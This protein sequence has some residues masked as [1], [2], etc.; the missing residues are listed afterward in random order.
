[1]VTFS[2]SV[3]ARDDA[4]L[5]ALL[6]RRPD[7]ASP[8]PST[9]LSLAARAMSRAS[10]HRAVVSLDVAHLEVLESVH[11]LEMIGDDATAE[12][13]IS[14]VLGTAPAAESAAG[15]VGADSSTRSTA[16]EKAEGA[17]AP[18]RSTGTSA[19]PDP[20]DAPGTPGTLDPGGTY[21]A[22][23]ARLLSVLSDL[24]E[25]ALLWRPTPTTY[26]AAPGVD[27]VQDT[28]PAGLGPSSAGSPAPSS[29]STSSSGN[30]TP[31]SARYL[32]PEA[33][34][35]TSASAAA[36]A[37]SP[38]GPAGHQTDWAAAVTPEM[39]AALEDAPAGARSIL[40]ALTW[41]PP[42]GRMPSTADGPTAAPTRWLLEQGFV[43]KADAHHVLLPREV[44]LA[45]RGG[46]THR[47]LSTPPPLP[48]PALDPATV[49]AESAR[50]AQEVVRLVTD[51]VAVW[52]E[53]PAATLR[54]GGLGVRDLRRL[55]LRLEV[56]ERTAAFVVELASMA[57]LVVDDGDD[58]ASFAPTLDADDWL[59]ED[60]PGRWATL[61]SAWHSSARTPWLVGSRD[62]RGTLRSAL[63]PELHR[64]WVPRLRGEVLGVLRAAPAASVPADEVT[65]VLRWRAPRAVPPHEA[66][67]ALLAEAALLGVTGAG[68]LSAA[69]E[70]LAGV[71]VLTVADDAARTALAGAMAAALPDAVDDL[72]LQGDLTGIVPGRPTPGLEALLA[73]SAAVE[74]RGS[75]ITVRFTPESVTRALD[76]GR[77]G[78]E[79]L[80]EL[81]SHSRSGLPQPLE[82]LVRD[83][84][85]RHGQLRLGAA[86]S[87]V[88][89]EDP[90]LL[91]GLVEDPRLRGLGLFR[92]APTVLAASAAPAQLLA[93]L[94]ERG[95]APAMEGPDGQ[96]VHADRRTPRVRLAGRRGRRRSPGVDGSTRGLAPER[97]DRLLALVAVLRRGEEQARATQAAG[98]AA[99]TDRPGAGGSAGTSASATRTAA[100]VSARRARGTSPSAASTRTTSTNPA[101]SP[102]SPGAGRSTGDQGGSAQG[103]PAAGPQLSEG[104]TEPVVA[105]ALLREA[106]ADGREVLVDIVGPSG[107]VTRRRLR[108]MR[109]DAGRLRAVD[110]ARE[111]EL[112]VAVHRIANVEP[113]LATP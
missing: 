77:T 34:G 46:R 89:V 64:A 113:I 23:V 82:Y 90:V 96:V 26:R 49:E 36:S 57:G 101:G 84:A 108:P 1:M 65:A 70:V 109:L 88:R 14:A 59:A 110:V 104:T 4:R 51:L 16:P 12:R 42:V 106:A 58:P 50:A 83:A 22:D 24:E 53:T 56:D 66:V 93:A 91:A 63:E 60:L 68:A 100:G 48:E 18:A 81:A 73:D 33:S 41:G 3:R 61:V 80:A 6:A 105:L 15:A 79:L 111:S 75:A 87:Y 32:T 8:S 72:L 74:S 19:A 20:T 112:T 94:R 47:G 9:L 102:T 99:Q 2:D 43:R 37:H 45:L 38:S 54:S 92:V 69:G 31:T 28:F 29:A 7:L 86:S 17:V 76:A 13:V 30:L 10:V 55:A 5:V 44:A 71:P 39:R 107:D 85:R 95:L 40:A 98:P 67:D 97:P 78:D 27:E 25:M 35:T 62:E 52:Q 21:A 103:D 11:V